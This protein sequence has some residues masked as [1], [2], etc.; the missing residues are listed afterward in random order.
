VAA[1]TTGQLV[2]LQTGAIA[3]LETSDIVALTTGQWVAFSSG[4]IRALEAVDLAA[5]QTTD[6]AALSTGQF[7]AL[8]DTQF[9]SF[10]TT[11]LANLS[12]REI[13]AMNAADIATLSQAD[14]HALT[15]G[16]IAVM[17]TGQIVAFSAA[18]MGGFEAAD[19]A[20]LTTAQAHVLTTGQIDALT[21]P[22]IQAFETADLAAMTMTQYNAFDAGD[23]AA[24][25]T[26]QQAALN[27]V[28]PIVLDLDGNGIQTLA[29]SEGV[30]FNIYA[31]GGTE[32][33]GWVGGKD[34]L[35]VRDINGDGV[36]NDGRE[37]FGS[38]TQLA[39]GSRAGN[40][41]AAM[42][43]LDSNHDGKLTKADT[44][45]SE[46][47]VWVDGNHDGITEAGELHGLVD[48]GIVE[49]NLD[50]AKGTQVD[51]GNL[52]GMTSSFTTSDGKEHAM[53]D[54]WFAKDSAH[55][56]PALGDLLAGPGHDLLAG[57]PATP[58]HDAAAAPATPVATPPVAAEPTEAHPAMAIGSLQRL[59]AEEELLRL[60]QQ[61]NLI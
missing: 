57:L 8:S 31:I 51:H 10:G 55:P 12:T 56:A 14:I 50:Y 2:A 44:H 4:Q 38:A 36:I 52:L 16:Q 18:Q 3:A 53:A 1:L 15:T 48:L 34:G 29:A 39:D 21:T 46:L 30:H 40:G 17:T 25:N 42:A 6:L 5:M 58:A 35:L 24:L 60:Q 41:Y 11:Q 19:I 28:T 13:V 22:Q 43:A 7:A 59:S 20:A 45:F 27:S 32:K 47:K 33:V 54:V 49:L 61:Q 23:M 9:D 26:A 37:L